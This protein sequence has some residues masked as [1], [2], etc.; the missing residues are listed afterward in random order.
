M[1][2]GAE[3]YIMKRLRQK[4]EEHYGEHVFFAQIGGSRTDVVCFR[5]MASFIINEKWHTDK[6]EDPLQEAKTIVIAAI[7]IIR[8]EILERNYSKKEYPSSDEIKDIATGR[9]FLT[10]CLR[11]FI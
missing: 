5:N 7:K 10:P 11:V 9:Q 8:E 4:L 2:E 3:V 1:A 6:N